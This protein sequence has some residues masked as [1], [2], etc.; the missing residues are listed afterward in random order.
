MRVRRPL[1]ARLAGDE[2]ERAGERAGGAQHERGD[3]RD[4]RDDHGGEQRADGEQQLDRDAV[5]GEGGREQ[6]VA[7]AQQLGPQRAHRGADRGDGEAADQRAADQRD[8][9]RVGLGE[10]DQQRR[11]SPRRRWPAAAARRAGRSGR[12]A[13]SGRGRRS[14]R[15]CR[16]RRRRGRRP[17]RS[18]A[19]RRG[20]ARP[21]ARRA[22]TA[23]ARA[24][25]PAAAARRAACA[26]WRRSGRSRTWPTDATA[27]PRRPP[28]GY[29]PPDGFEP[30]Y[31]T[32]AVRLPRYDADPAV[33]FAPHHPKD[34]VSPHPDR[35]HPTRSL[36]ILSLGALAFA[37][38]QT[39][40]IPALGELTHQL[41]TDASG[42]AWVLT[43]YLLAAAVATPIAGRLGDM[44]GKRRLLVGSLARLRRSAPS[45]PRSATRSAASSP[46]ASC[47]AS[48]A[49]SSRSASGS[50]ATSSRARRSRA[51][52]G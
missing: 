25:T 47:R 1:A 52:S 24:S 32:R 21:R 19:P 11:S 7:P 43:G 5:E 41:D 18:R 16:R 15:R 33:R 51:A 20:R 28:C 42:I 14:R 26:G 34:V 45:S 10:R 8:G 27:A 36:F 22:R 9:R 48:A 37:L 2:E 13:G 4:E 50:S 17:R 23:A 31:R 40:L 35:P 44:F 39:M 6:L 46:A 38:A 49:A 3:R 29:P 12:S 30:R